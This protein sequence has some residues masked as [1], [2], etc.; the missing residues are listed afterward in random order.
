MAIQPLY[1][2]HK[3]TR[4]RQGSTKSVNCVLKN[5]S[6]CVLTSTYGIMEG[7]AQATDAT[8]PEEKVSD[9]GGPQVELL[10]SRAH[11]QTHARCL[12]W[13]LPGALATSQL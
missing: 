5:K 10:Y 6:F 13:S 1:P 9:P 12:A 8:R 4:M 3:K 7:E 11:L 2:I